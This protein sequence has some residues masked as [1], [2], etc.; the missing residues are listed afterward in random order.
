MFYFHLKRNDNPLKPIS[1]V[2]S[3]EED[4]NCVQ[5]FKMAARHS[6]LSAAVLSLAPYTRA[7]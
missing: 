7:L 1:L 3:E 5:I 4:H 6:S 2:I